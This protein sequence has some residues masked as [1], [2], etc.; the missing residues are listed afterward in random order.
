LRKNPGMK[1]AV[2]GASGLIGSALVPALAAGHDVIR[3]VRREP[4]AADEVAWDP[5]AGTIDAARLAGVDAFVTLSGE[6]IGRRWTAARKAEILQSRVS[7]AELLARTA[8][9]LEPRPSVFVSAGGAGIYGDRGDEVLTE[10]SE[11]GSGFLA[12][13][14]RAWEAAA[15][16]ARAAGIRTVNFRQGIVLSQEGG[17]LER[18]LLPFKLGV[19]GR[20]GSGRQWFSWVTL[21]DAVAAYR[22]V[23]ETDLSGPVNL[24]SPNP[25]TNAQFT[26]ALGRALGRP[27][28]LPVPAVAVRTLFG[29]M[30]EALLLEGQRML[31]ARLLDAGFEFRHTE[32]TP[33]FEHTLGD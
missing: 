6:T 24:G 7:T 31:P 19:G 1:V 33:A 11:T 5:D 8:A 29:A 17:A 9:E 16:P 22:F 27:T 21:H 15:E 28:I 30:G 3:L 13:V 32:L 12:D 14:G 2:S 25:V 4:R 23:L 18:M 20:L 26:K 10:E